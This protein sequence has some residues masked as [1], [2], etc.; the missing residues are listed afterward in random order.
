MDEETELEQ[1]RVKA[2]VY[3]TLIERYADFIGSQEEKTVPELKNLVNPGDEAVQ[4][5][6]DLLLSEFN[7]FEFEKDFLDFVS[8]AFN[9]VRSF[10]EVHADLSISYWLNPREIIDL[11][12]ADAFDKAIL[13]CSLLHSIGCASAKTRVIDLEGGFTHVVVVFSFGGQKLLLDPSQEEGIASA[14]SE[15]ELFSSYEFS[16][17]KFARNLYEFNN[18]EYNEFE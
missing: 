4:E 2:A 11:G 18:E 5:I 10:K 15:E 3:K 14:E 8:K 13:L 12:A 6:K 1:L 7:G 16:G 9:Y 17:K